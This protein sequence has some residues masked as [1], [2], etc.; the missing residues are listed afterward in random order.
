MMAEHGVHIALDDVA[1][2]GVNLALLA[3]CNFSIIKLDRH[4]TAELTAERPA[5]AW[6]A[7]LGSLLRNT[8]IQVVAEGVES[9]YQATT[10]A[11]AGVQMAQGY[12]FTTP[13]PAYELK[14]YYKLTNGHRGS[15]DVGP[16]QG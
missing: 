8:S 15:S 9:L 1:M 12:F 4:L 13:L 6:L 5:P 14:A 11:E 3:R 16:G 2:S 10:L 7:A